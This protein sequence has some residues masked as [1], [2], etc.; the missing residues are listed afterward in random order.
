[1]PLPPF[2]GF[3]CLRLLLE[4]S[5]RESGSSRITRE[6][7]GGMISRTGLDEDD[8]KTCTLGQWLC[9]GEVGSDREIEIR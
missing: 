9:G 3:C 5:L 8:S 4:P 7:F 2:V 1:M 6:P